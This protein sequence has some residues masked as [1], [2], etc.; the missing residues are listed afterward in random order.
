MNRRD[1]LRAGPA[2]AL[3]GAVPT[4]AFELPQEAAQG[5]TPV[6]ALFREW[7]R[8]H[9]L[10]ESLSGL[11]DDE[12]DEMSDVRAEIEAR[13]FAEPAQ[14]FQDVCA[15]LLALSLDGADFMDD[16]HNSGKKICEEAK[17]LLA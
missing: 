6:M 14:D 3:V 5:D 13:L 8:Q 10:M 9:Q 17:A 11:S 4:A 15:K 1:L 2:L 16:A 7:R 12:Y